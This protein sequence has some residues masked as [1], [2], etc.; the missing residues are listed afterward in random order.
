ML[1]V[2]GRVVRT[3]I[4]HVLTATGFLLFCALGYYFG[5]KDF[6]TEWGGA[7]AAAI[8]IFAL[9]FKSSGYWV[10]S[11]VNASLW[12]VLF[13]QDLPMLAGLQVSYII[14]S[15]YGLWQWANVRFRIGYDH[16]VWTDNLGTVIASG[17]FL[18]TIIAYS[19]LEGYAFTSWWWVE[20]FGVAI[21]IASNWMDAFKYKTNWIGWT[22]TNLLFGPLFF[23][24]GLWGPFAL[25]FLYQ[26]MCCVGFYNWYR[27]EKEMAA[28]GEVELVG[29]ARYV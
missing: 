17:I 8:C 12:L 7:V 4:Y 5:G 19:R 15:I 2:L 9:I 22:L 16:N 18:Y 21:S 6:L 25:T 1:N 29:G 28:R 14:F 27:E 26:A 10:W 11:I 24:L 23:H 20:F 3:K 13:A